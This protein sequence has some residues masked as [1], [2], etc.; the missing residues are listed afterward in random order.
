MFQVKVKF[1]VKLGYDRYCCLPHSAS[2]TM[3]NGNIIVPWLHRSSNLLDQRFTRRYIS[4]VIVKP[5]HLCLANRRL[6]HPFV[7][8]SASYTVTDPPSEKDIFRA[9]QKYQGVLRIESVGSRGLGLI[10]LKN[11][12]AG[13]LVV[14]GEALNSCGIQGIHTIQTDV[15]THTVMDLPARLLN[16]MCGTANLYVRDNDFAAYNWYAHTDIHRGDELTF[17]YETTEYEMHGLVCTCGSPICRG[18][19]KGF[20]HNQENV[21]KVW[22]PHHIAG[23]LCEMSF[24]ET[25]KDSMETFP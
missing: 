16:H 9:N 3:R 14:I 15:K 22:Q 17:D 8:R 6:R 13:D 24:V 21:E 18:K 25:N 5:V 20:R 4:C 23:Y 19:L 2:S 12:T 7:K 11:F 10:A 1:H